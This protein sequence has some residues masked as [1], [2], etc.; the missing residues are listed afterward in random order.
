MAQG[1]DPL[2]GQ[3]DQEIQDPRVDQDQDPLISLYQ[4]VIKTKGGKKLS[5]VSRQGWH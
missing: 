5:R 2:V 4:D 3:E 1:Q